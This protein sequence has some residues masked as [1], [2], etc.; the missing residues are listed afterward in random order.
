MAHSFSCG[1]VRHIV[2]PQVA[3]SRKNPGMP[4]QYLM[5]PVVAVSLSKHVM[6]RWNAET[7]SLH[8]M[9]GVYTGRFATIASNSVFLQAEEEFDDTLNAKL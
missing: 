1:H 3:G 6:A 7:Q 4:L 5:C 9:E 8:L 2:W